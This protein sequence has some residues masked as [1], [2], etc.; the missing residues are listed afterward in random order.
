MQSP[1]TASLG[2]ISHQESWLPVP[3]HERPCSKTWKLKS[4]VVQN[5]QI[6][7]EFVVEVSTNFFVSNHPQAKVSTV[8]VRP[9][10]ATR[11]VASLARPVFHKAPGPSGAQWTTLTRSAELPWKFMALFNAVKVLCWSNYNFYGEELLSCYMLLHYILYIYMHIYSVA[12]LDPFRIIFG[13]RETF[14]CVCL[15]PTPEAHN[16][17]ASCNPGWALVGD[18]CKAEKHS[19]QMI[20]FV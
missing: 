11:R 1:Y 20:G 8:F 7:S 5:K 4:V 19:Q 9:M 14:R 6:S 18:K 15:V 10:P 2:S 13:S 3:T 12:F 17:C 16:Q